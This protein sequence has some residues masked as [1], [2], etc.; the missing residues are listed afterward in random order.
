[1]DVRSSTSQAHIIFIANGMRVGKDPAIA[2]VNGELWD[3]RRPI[4][5]GT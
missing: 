5:D 3:L 4:S 1:M 2:C